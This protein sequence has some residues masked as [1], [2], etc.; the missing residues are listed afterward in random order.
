M[1]FRSGSVRGALVGALGIGL[2]ETLGRAYLPTLLRG[3][4]SAPVADAV[5]LALSSMLIYVAMA[6]VL[7]VRPEG[8][9]PAQR[10][11][12]AGRAGAA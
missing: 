7:L 10:R 3:L 1:L 9:F 2:L 12:E 8:L 4:F 6:A 5:G 11:A